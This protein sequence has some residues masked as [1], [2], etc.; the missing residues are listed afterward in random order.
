M[1]KIDGAVSSA[2]DQ[3]KAIDYTLK[4]PDTL[5]K[6]KVAGEISTRVLTKVIELCTSGSRI[7]EICAKGDALIV[8]ETNKVYK[9]KQVIKGIAFPTS[10]SVNHIAAHF[11][12]L[13][14]DPE[15]QLTLN[16][17]D[18]L[19]IS[20]GAQI[21]GFGSILGIYDTPLH[22]IAHANSVSGDTII[23]GGGEIEG[24]KADVLMAAHLASEAA[25]R[26]VKPGGKNWDVTDAVQK[27]AESFGCKPCEGILSHSQE[28]NVVDGK[29]EII[30]NPSEN[31]KR[32]THLFEEGDVF[33]IDIL[34]SSGDGKV[35]TVQS[36]TT[37]FKR[38]KDLKYSLKMPTSR[39][40]LSEIDKTFGAFPFTLRALSEKLDEKSARM[41]VI[42]PQKHGL[43]LAYDV[44]EGKSD[45]FIALFHTTIA[46]GS[47]GTV[48]LAGP[49]SFDA[50]KCKTEKTLQDEDLK[51]I[52]AGPLKV[53]KPKKKK[54]TEEQTSKTEDA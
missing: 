2:K 51:S 7:I 4:N 40:A 47:N 34:V 11:S 26:L 20:L 36:R 54:A 45:D 38:A 28:R 27:I 5:T 52:I 46:L 50:S 14:S 42:E 21:D 33:G 8:E 15:A 1:S 10:L 18:L 30:L 44:F 25:I 9:G 23:V 22:I 48:K 41:G 17:G 19:K 31:I 32:E 29:K 13:P 43:L 49:S 39:R 37:V 3:S 35:K 53:P 16:D 6:Y 24:R 12:P